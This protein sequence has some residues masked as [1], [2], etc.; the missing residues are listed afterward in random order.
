MKPRTPGLGPAAS[1]AFTGRPS[2]LGA[3][4]Y[5]VS[6]SGA[7]TIASC[8]DAPR[9]LATCM[10]GLRHNSSTLL[11]LTSAACLCA[12]PVSS[13]QPPSPSPSASAQQQLAA[14]N[15]LQRLRDALA[16]A[17]GTTAS[18]VKF[19]GGRPQRRNDQLVS[20]LFRSLGR[21][22]PA[23]AGA[24][25]ADDHDGGGR[26]DE[27]LLDGDPVQLKLGNRQ[28]SLMTIPNYLTTHHVDDGL[29]SIRGPDWDG[30]GGS[31]WMSAVALQRFLSSTGLH[32]VRGRRCVELGTGTGA[33]S[34]A[35]ARL[36]AVQ[37]V[38]TDGNPVMVALADLNAHLN[39]DQPELSRFAAAR[40]L[41]G[42]E[43]PSFPSDFTQSFSTVLLTDLLYSEA[44]VG[45]L[46]DAVMAVCTSDCDVLVA[47]EKRDMILTRHKNGTSR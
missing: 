29:A 40:Y 39:L 3:P 26:S 11:L 23:A 4:Q 18:A 34:I 19:R 25:V 31:L 8:V 33:V 43:A 41:W 14:A 21:R 9:A 5:Q 1:R 28:A 35:A 30:T 6:I 20:G 38:A 10:M 15:S 22:R 46:L 42:G 27:E 7:A 13:W 37:A 32:F 36:G 16:D 24:A 17:S 47:Y 45:V 2:Q 12:P 44:K